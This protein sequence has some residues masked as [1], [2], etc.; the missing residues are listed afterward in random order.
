MRALSFAGRNVR[1]ILRDRLTLF[2][3]LVFP[4][5]ILTLMSL[6]GRNVPEAPFSV[7]ALA[8]GI[9]VFG[10][11]FMSLFAGLLVARDR[12]GSFMVRLIASPAYPRE[13]ICGYLLPLIPVGTAQSLICLLFSAFFGLR[14]GAGTLLAAVVLIP[15]DLFY[16][17]AGLLLGSVL[18]ERQVGGI[19]GALMTNLS[20]WLSGAWFDPGLVGG[21]FERLANLFPFIHATRAARL[22]LAGNIPGMLPHLAVTAVWAAAMFA[23]AVLV[24][25]W[26]LRTV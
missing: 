14:A 4:L 7:S 9:A 1:E 17:C 5:I 26:R 3:G 16:I 2:F 18:S 25:R 20:A 8:P 19:C 15:A 13:L 21:A 23:S 22:A 10:L 6:I 11:S 12:S 24:L